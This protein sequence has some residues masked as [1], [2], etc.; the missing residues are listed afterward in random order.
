[1]KLYSNTGFDTF[2]WQ[3]LQIIQMA[4][5]RRADTPLTASPKPTNGHGWHAADDGAMMPLWFAGDCLPKVLIDN[6][7]LP[8]VEESDDDDDDEII[9]CNSCQI[10]VSKPVFKY[11]L[12]NTQPY[13][14]IR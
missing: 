11:N 7:D 4:V 6:D 2:I 10:N 12:M 3:L 13:K 14:N 9:I 1:M 8:N 5:W